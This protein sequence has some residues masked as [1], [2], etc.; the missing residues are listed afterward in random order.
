MIVLIL[1]GAKDG[2]IDVKDIPKLISQAG[3]VSEQIKFVGEFFDG[4]V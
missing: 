3:N 4:K 2:H 1:I